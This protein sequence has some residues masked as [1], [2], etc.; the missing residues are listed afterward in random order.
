M[1]AAAI[2][3]Q[4]NEIIADTYDSDPQL[5]TGNTLDLA[6]ELLRDEGVFSEILPPLRVLDVGMGTGMFLHKLRLSV[7]RPVLPFGLDISEKMIEVATKKLPDLVAE[8]DDGAN[9]SRHFDAESFDIAATHFVT[10]FVPIEELS[11]EIHRKL[12]SGGMW[13][14]VGGTSSGYPALRRCATHPM[15]RLLFGGPS[16]SLEQMICPSSTTQV[17]QVM[18]RSGFEIAASQT[19]EPRLHFENFDAFLD[20]AYHGGWLT[21]FIEEIGLHQLR[22]W[23]KRLL[24]QMFFPMTDNHSITLVVARKR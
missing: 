22:G 1:E 10:G 23:K 21:P 18:E 7:T 17:T 19:I 2:R 5:L 3:R 14:F 24:D 15:V 9:L 6:I 20:F 8:V 16:R 11:L 4:Y 13:S 12:V